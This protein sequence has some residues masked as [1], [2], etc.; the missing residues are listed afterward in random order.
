MVSPGY[1]GEPDTLHRPRYFAAIIFCMM[2]PLDNMLAH[3]PGVAVHLLLYQN[4]PQ[5]GFDAAL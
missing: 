1:M 5:L 2:R 3:C 4:G